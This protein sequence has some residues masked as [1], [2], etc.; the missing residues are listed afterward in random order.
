MAQSIRNGAIL[1]PLSYFSFLLTLLACNAANITQNGTSSVTSI[2]PIGLRV[3][4]KSKGMEILDG[5]PTYDDED[6]FEAT[7]KNVLLSL[8]KIKADTA[9]WQ[10][11]IFVGTFRARRLDELWFSEVFDFPLTD[12]GKKII[13]FK[14]VR[15]S[16]EAN[17]SITK[18]E[19]RNLIH[20]GQT[21]GY[22]RVR[23]G[24][25][26]E[27]YVN[28]QFRSFQGYPLKYKIRIYGHK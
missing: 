26:G 8:G 9:R 27:S 15:L 19:I 25:L 21:A 2:V 12:D 22:C 28:I 6:E 14:T 10:R 23:R 24:G 16:K 3:L 5:I 7:I 1:R 13:M 17:C 20:S 11:N 18:M 4:H